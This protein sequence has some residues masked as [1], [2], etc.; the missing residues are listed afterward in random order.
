MEQHGRLE[1]SGGGWRVQSTRASPIA[2]RRCWRALTEAEHLAAWFPTEI[3]GD[4]AEG[5]SLRF[6]FR[7]AEGPPLDGTM[8]RYDPPR[9]L[10][11]RWG[12]E[13]LRFELR[14]EGDGTELRFVNSFEALGKAAR[15][16]AG[17]HVC[18]DLLALALD[19]GRATAP[20]EARWREVHPTDVERFG[21][22]AATIGPPGVG[23]FTRLKPTPSARPCSGGHLS[24]GSPLCGPPN[25]H[26]TP[27][28]GDI[29]GAP[30]RRQATEALGLDGF[31]RSDH[32]LTIGDVSGLP[33][34]TDSWV[35][36]AGLARDTSRIRLGTMLTAG[37]FRLP[38]PLAITVANVDEMSGGRVELG[39]GAGW[40][41]KEH[42][43]YGIPFPRTEGA[44]RS[45]R[46]TA[47]DHHRPLA[48]APWRD[49]QLL[50]PS[51][52]TERLP[53][54][55]QA[56]ATTP[57]ARHRRRVGFQAHAGHR[58]PIR[59]RVQHSDA[60]PGHG[61]GDVRQRGSGLRGDRSGPDGDHQVD[62]R[63]G[64]RRHH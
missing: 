42:P 5:A 40:Y 23:R 18:L 45:P 58:R 55:A 4:R 28:R 27:A 52:P 39:L 29:R 43:A 35:T 49:V 44:R 31:F 59:R 46:G 2:Q 57:S 16:A 15:D 51:F 32:Y 7:N 12:D 3:Q 19:G 38:G 53:G 33:G 63:R 20:L 24:V 50:G 62:R 6:V 17:W 64:L 13:T 47:R 54:P 34:P 56:A 41:E 14:A 60:A 11:Y 1:P 10:E 37:T 21:P 30:R 22:A 9:L 25:F 26:R 61:A 48:I 36:L 8:T